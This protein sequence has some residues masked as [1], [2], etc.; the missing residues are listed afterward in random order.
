MLMRTADLPE[1]DRYKILSGTVLPR[2]IAWVSTID[3]AGIPNLAPFSFFNVACSN[4]MT[5]M[6]S[7]GAADAGKPNGKKDTL[8]NIE[9]IPEFVVNLTNEETA[10][11][12][13]LSATVLPH[14]QSEFAWAGVTPAP[15]LT[16]QAPRVAEAPVAFECTL[17]QIVTIGS[18][19]EGSSIVFGEVQGIYLHDDIYQGGYIHLDAFRPIGRLSGSGYA[20]VRELFEMER[21]PAP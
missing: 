16:I 17:Q 1:R 8:A 13:N 10:A 14:G 19:Q 20:Y 3:K 9:A 21:V 18:A 12:M 7:V 4:P 15:S 2:P 11:A 5:L 6:F